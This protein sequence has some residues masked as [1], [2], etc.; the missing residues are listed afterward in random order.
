M[1]R[2]LVLLAGGLYWLGWVT[3]PQF[4]GVW[5]LAFFVPLVLMII[6]VTR[7]EA[8][9]FSRKFVSVDAVLRRNLVRYAGLT[10]TS[11]LSTQ[12]VWTID[13]VMINSRQGLG[14][15]G[16]YGTASYFAAVIAIPATTLYKVSRCR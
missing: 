4:L 7:D 10:L 15:T 13:K 11:A 8:L 6:S 16:I 14:D 1:Q 5:L 12:I 2:V 9:F 3:F